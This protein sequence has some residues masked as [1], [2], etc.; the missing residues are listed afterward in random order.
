[1]KTFANLTLYSPG[2][3]LF[4]PHTL[5][6][7]LERLE[8]VPSDVFDLFIHDQSVGVQAIAAGVVV[9]IYQIPDDDYGVFY[10]GASHPVLDGATCH[11]TYTDAR[12]HI[13]SGVLI[14]AD[15]SVLMAWDASFF[16][17]Y[18]ANYQDRLK[19]SDY[20]EIPPGRYLCVISGYTG[21]APPLSPMGYGLHMEP[22][23]QF[24]A[25]LPAAEFDFS[26]SSE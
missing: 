12:L 17:D 5:Q 25:S 2:I 13:T 16:C 19:N 22:V 11:F 23:K 18:L 9:P 8:D 14:A 3:V 20:L 21:L 7:F 24:P 15:L 26:L 10:L 1:M 6:A 4:D